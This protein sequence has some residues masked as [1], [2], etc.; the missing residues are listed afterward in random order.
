V[1]VSREIHRLV[2]HT[3]DSPDD[4]DIGFTEID[5][6]HKERFSG[7]VVG[8]IRIYCGYHFVIRRDGTIEIGRPES[9]VGAHVAGHNKDSIGICWIGRTQ[10][11]PRQREALLTLLDS[12]MRKYALSV[13]SVYGHR[14]LAQGKTCPNIDMDGLR[15]DLQVRQIGGLT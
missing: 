7:V 8:G 5:L 2:V 3:S 15:Y 1:A 12:L 6:W 13:K 9:V 4:R 10:M 14:E 11:D